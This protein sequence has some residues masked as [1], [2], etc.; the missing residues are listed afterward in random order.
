MFDVPTNEEVLNYFVRE[1]S[2]EG[3]TL[4][5]L[6]RYGVHEG[7]EMPEDYWNSMGL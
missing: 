3:M 4:G 5:Y 2:F 7:D 1:I 6:Y